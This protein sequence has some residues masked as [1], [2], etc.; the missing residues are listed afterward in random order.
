MNCLLSD[1]SPWLSSGYASGDRFAINAST[2]PRVILRER[3]IFTLP[4][5]PRFNK[6]YTCER[7]MPMIFATWFA[8]KRIGKSFIQVPFFFIRISSMSTV[9]CL[10]ASNLLCLKHNNYALASQS[11]SVAFAY[12]ASV[13]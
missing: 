5:C 11:T 9:V 2:C 7:L 13:D 10:S 1:K 6:T 12:N 3:P 4:K 8:V